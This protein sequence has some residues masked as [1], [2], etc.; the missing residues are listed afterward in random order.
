[1]FRKLLTLFIVLGVVAVSANWL[2]NQP[3]TMQIEWLGW[4]L[5]MPAS[6]AVTFVLVFGLLLVFFDRLFRTVIGIPKWVG[7]HL[8]RRRDDAGHRALTLGF[9]AV[10]AGE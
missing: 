2:S 4:R 6:L 7:G 9:L 1:M 5:E 3:G 10:S 8:R